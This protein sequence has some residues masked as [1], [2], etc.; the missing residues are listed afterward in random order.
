MSIGE[1]PDEGKPHV[2]FCEGHS[3]SSAPA[4]A[5]DKERFRYVY[6]TNQQTYDSYPDKQTPTH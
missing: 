5:G 4:N 6:S 2:R 3:E 1:E